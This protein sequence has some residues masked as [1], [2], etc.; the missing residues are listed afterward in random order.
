MIRAVTFEREY[1]SG[2]GDIARKLAERLGWKLWDQALTDE[3]ARLMD[4]PSRTVQEREERKD[5][6]TYRLFKSFMR[7]SFEGTLNAPRLNMV[8]ADCIKTVG[9]QVVLAAAEKGNA[10]I[11]G[12]GS[13]YHLY[14]RPDALHVFVYAPFEEK[15]RRL[16]ATGKSEKEAIELVDTVDRDRSEYIKKYF[17]VDW[18]ARHYFHL[19]I[20]STM[21]D[22]IVVETILHSVSVLE[23][24]AA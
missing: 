18:P 15:V 21:G 14:G 7:G 13:A 19:M 16:Q 6:F 1:G 20:N 10:V 22:E 23:R 8:D 2:A 4:C 12:R 24:R 11:V 3:I 9:R 5:P 17:D